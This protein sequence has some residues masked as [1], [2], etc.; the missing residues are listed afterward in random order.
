[1]SNLK[2]Y[3]VA[4]P[5]QQMAALLG[6][7]A[8]RV[9]RRAGFAPDFLD[10]EGRGVTAREYFVL[11]QATFEEVGRPGFALEIARQYA[12][13]PVVPAVLAFSSSPNTEIGLSRLA[14]F[15]PLVGPVKLDVRRSGGGVEITIGSTDPD[16]PMPATTAAFEA[17][18]FLECARKFTAHQIVPLSVGLPAGAGD[19]PE[20]ERFFG[21]TATQSNL[22]RLSLSLEDAHR[23]LISENA[24][25]WEWLEIDL[26]RQLAEREDG[27]AITDRVRAALVEVLPAGEASAD[28]VS[29]RL[30]LSKRS[31]QRRLKEADATFQSV[32]DATRSELSIKYL[33]KGNLNVEEISY[34]LAYRD[35][36]SFYRAFHTWT[37]MTPAEA[38]GQIVQ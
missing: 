12:G 14:L 24:E 6:I 23:P 2:R 9:L 32:L 36:N 31:L 17:A 33:A 22:A 35:P 38:R 37:G 20:I 11:W 1:M 27:A 10:N 8:A 3:P 29:R 4:K 16:A 30:G 7:D 25:F 13:T 28:A 19:L 15:K 26:K 5:M 21:V 18:Y 34:L